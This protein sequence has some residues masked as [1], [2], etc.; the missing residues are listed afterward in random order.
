ML[1][2]GALAGPAG[3]R[4]AEFSDHWG[5]YRVRLGVGLGQRDP[6]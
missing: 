1:L 2:F 3:W 6:A 4:A 5:F